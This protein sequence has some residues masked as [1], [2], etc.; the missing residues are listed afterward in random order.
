MIPM[1]YRSQLASPVDEEVFY[2]KD[3]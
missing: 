2:L 3:E 1:L